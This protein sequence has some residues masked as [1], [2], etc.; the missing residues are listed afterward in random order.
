M[1]E[2]ARGVAP[3][4]WIRCGSSAIFFRRLRFRIRSP[5]DGL[6][7]APCS[8]PLNRAILLLVVVAAI[9][10]LAL[11]S[12]SVGAEPTGPVRLAPASAVGVDLDTLLVGGYASG[13][14]DE[15]VHAL[16]GDLGPEERLM[17][18]EHLERIFTDRVGDGLGDVGRLRVAYERAVR[19]D[20]TTRSIRVLG[21]EVAAGGRLHTAFYF[22]HQ[23]RP[24]YFDPF[25]SIVEDPSWSGP[26]RN[27]RIS[28]AFGSSRMHPILRR[29]LPHTGV[30]YAA[31]RGEPV[32]A[33]ADGI[34]VSAGTNGGYGTMVELRHP[35][36]FG[37]RYAHL[38]SI[39]PTVQ[40]A[41]LVRR[42]DVIG[43]VGMTGLATGPHL[44]Y[45]VRRRGQPVDPVALSL[46]AA[47]GG[48]IAGSERWPIERRRL[49]E[50]LARVPTVTGATSSRRD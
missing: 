24:G 28:S 45:E 14:F 41:R 20:G 1:E 7:L 40:P 3:A 47:T 33:T 22:E 44:H 5:D 25:G 2:A 34:V 31:P 48:D 19:P 18:G 38:Q 32:R 27:L 10:V 4:G 21:A 9:G 23:G 39:E 37:T 42:G 30:D 29:V 12:R 13:D 6:L 46:A 11:G 36:G 8:D 49:T 16:A 26:L 50:L 15:A 43:Y 17:V 35:N